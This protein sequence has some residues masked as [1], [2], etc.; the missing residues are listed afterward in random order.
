MS[1]RAR[2]FK[3]ETVVDAALDLFWRKGYKSCSMA[4]IVKKSGV[5]RYGLYQAFK[6]KDQLYCAALRHYHKKIRSLFIL[7]FCCKDKKA[8]LESLEQ[9]FDIMLEQLERGIHDGCFAHQAAIE[10][11]SKNEDVNEI[12]NDI[13]DEAKKAYRTIIENGIELGQIRDLPVDDLVTYVMGIQRAVIAMSKQNCSMNERKKYVSCA[14]ML[15]RTETP[16][17]TEHSNAY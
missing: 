2:E 8:D 12:V 13:F 5:A 6:D 11:A 16:N 1:P 4:D 3:I 17:P 15:L 9:H 10:Q 7:P 14:L